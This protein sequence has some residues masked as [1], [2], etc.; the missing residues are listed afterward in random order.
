MQCLAHDYLALLDRLDASGLDWPA[1]RALHL[2]RR[3][4]NAAA[5]PAKD[6]E[7]CALALDDD[8]IGLGYVLLDATWPEL[9]DLAGRAPALRAGAPALALAR[10]LADAPGAWRTLGWATLNALTR[11][12][13]T[14]AGWSLPAATDT[15]AG[16]APGP[17]E[18]LGMVGYFPPLVRR[19]AETGGRLTVLELR[20][21]LA[22]Q[23]APNV[24][25]V[26][27]P[28]ELAACT[29]VLV[30]ST[31]LLNDTL[32]AVLAACRSAR[33]VALLGPGASG[34][35]GPLWA[36]GVHVLAGTQ[37]TD[38]AGFVQALVEGRSWSPHARKFTLQRDDDPGLD[39]LLD[40][41]RG[42]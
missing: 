4:G 15:L 38:P 23:A 34:L 2:P 33:R 1:V 41:A 39:A 27:D 31:V 26:L 5:A 29:Q 3:A 8:S 21:E 32:D 9:E 30:T 36:R 6:A 10:H 25:V 13:S 11:H 14:R 35:P 12:L 37:V 24:R 20:A 40:R 17:G 28:A 22:G 7:F 16:L 42:R 18:H 19:V